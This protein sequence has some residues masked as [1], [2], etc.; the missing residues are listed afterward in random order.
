MEILGEGSAAAEAPDG[1][2]AQLRL[3][4]LRAEL[5]RVDAA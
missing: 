3:E 4:F 1:D 5:A 2:A